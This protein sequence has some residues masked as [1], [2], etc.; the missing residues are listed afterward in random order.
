MK[1]AP[2]KLRGIFVSAL[3][4][5]LEGRCAG[6]GDGVVL[7]ARAAAYTDGSD[8]FAILLKRDATGEDHH[9]AVVGGVDAEELAAG[10][11]VWCEVFGGDVKGA[12]G[13]CLLDGDVDGADP[14]IVHADVRDEVSAGVGYGDVHGLADFSGFFFCG[15]DD[16][17]CVC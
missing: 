10:L 17:A 7:I 15:G 14:C 2:L 11:R 8:D 13:P 16:A 3:R 6:F 12:G 4:K 9:F 1:N 5:Y